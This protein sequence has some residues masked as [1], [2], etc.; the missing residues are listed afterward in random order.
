MI[1]GFNKTGPLLITAKYLE[2]NWKSNLVRG[3]LVAMV[4]SHAPLDPQI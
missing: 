3:E 4:P 2:P 1:C